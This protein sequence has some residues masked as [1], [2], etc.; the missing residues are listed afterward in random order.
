M[1][2]K[3]EGRVAFITGVA[4]GQG[5]SHAL[6][7]ASEG[8][9]IIG[10]DNCANIS[11]VRYPGATKEQL[12]ETIEMVKALGRDIYA[13]KGDV[14]SIDD[15]Q[16]V[17][18]K[19]VERFG[20]LDTVIANAGVVVSAPTWEMTEQQWNDVIDINLTG[21]FHTVKAAVPSM[22]KA[23]NGGSIMFISSI[24]GMKGYRNLA[25]Y[26]SAKHGIVGLMR[27]LANEVAPYAIRV[28]TIHPTNI[29]TDMILNDGAY[30]TFAPHLEH[31]TKEDAMEGFAS[32]N[33]LPVPYID[34]SEISNAVLWLASD[35]SRYVTGVQLPVDAGVFVKT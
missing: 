12:S 29:E 26:T 10:I 5:R 7:L 34:P 9:D 32:I 14:R 11:S 35:E 21:V 33:L 1:A 18:D 28:N 16:G 15:M 25:N 31:P 2:G 23:N 6:R 20:R 4:R 19:G 8:A 27:T 3:L 13:V 17:V 22:I 30:K 24:A